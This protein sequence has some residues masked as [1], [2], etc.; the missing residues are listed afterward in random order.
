MRAKKVRSQ[1]QNRRA[2]SADVIQ[3]Y[4]GMT[5]SFEKV[6]PDGTLDLMSKLSH[7]LHALQNEKTPN[8][9]IELGEQGRE[10]VREAHRELVL[11]SLQS[12]GNR[13]VD[14]PANARSLAAGDRSPI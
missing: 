8:V 11:R 4:A 5:I 2:P 1:G 14:H 3:K 10:L 12:K 7:L 9:Q 6:F 13:A